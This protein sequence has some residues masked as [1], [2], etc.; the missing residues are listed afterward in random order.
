[1]TFNLCCSDSLQNLLEPTHSL[2][3]PSDIYLS[4]KSFFV[5]IQRFFVSKI[6]SLGFSFFAFYSPQG[7][8]ISKQ[9][10]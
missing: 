10:M 5:A 9:H 3:S 4:K 1:M 6:H 8:I 2:V 7:N